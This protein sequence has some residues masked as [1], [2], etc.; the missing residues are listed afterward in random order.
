MCVSAVD[1][2]RLGEL[3]ESLVYHQKRVSD[4]ANHDNG[5]RVETLLNG[6]INTN[7]RAPSATVRQSI[8]FQTYSGAGLGT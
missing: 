1:S 5:N 4:V 6:I 7:H 8:T 2:L 3:F